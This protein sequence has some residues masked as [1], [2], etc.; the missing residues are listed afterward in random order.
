MVAK[1]GSFPAAAPNRNPLHTLTYHARPSGSASK[2]A[3][4]TL[5]TRGTGAPASPNLTAAR[6]QRACGSAS[7]SKPGRSCSM[8]SNMCG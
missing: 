6:G 5:S 8:E 7:A 3:S 2:S 1:V 4:P